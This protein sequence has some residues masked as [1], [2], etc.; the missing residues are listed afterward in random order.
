MN[1]VHTRNLTCNL[2]YSPIG[3]G[4]SHGKDR[5]K[6]KRKMKYGPT[7][8][9]KLGDK[10]INAPNNSKLPGNSIDYL[11]ASRLSHR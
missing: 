7:K 4:L 11:R 2:L 1:V 10:D 6:N 8:N 9:A 5:R 3:V